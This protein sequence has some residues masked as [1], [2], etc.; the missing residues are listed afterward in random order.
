MH[1]RSGFYDL[2]WCPAECLGRVQLRELRT[3]RPRLFSTEPT[4]STS[5]N[6]TLPNL[7]T[8]FCIVAQQ[9]TRSDFTIPD[10]VANLAQTEC[11]QNVNSI[12]CDF[13]P[14][15]LAVRQRK[16]ALSRRTPHT[17]LDL[18]RTVTS[19]YTPVPIQ[20]GFLFCQESTGVDLRGI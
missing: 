9:P 11:V 18:S 14:S 15:G 8:V 16:S 6:L 4:V 5:Q 1:S 7:V 13:V 19:H 20:G 3:V 17:N 10:K 12:F 2:S